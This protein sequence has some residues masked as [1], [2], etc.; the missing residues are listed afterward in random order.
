[1][2]A[3]ELSSACRRFV[4]CFFLRP[5]KGSLG[6]PWGRWAQTPAAPHNTDLLA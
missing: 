5:E 1:M 4:S 3:S 2:L 6:S